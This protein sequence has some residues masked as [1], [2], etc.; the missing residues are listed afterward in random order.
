LCCHETT[1]FE[2]RRSSQA[3]RDQLQAKQVARFPFP[4]H[5]RIPNLAGAE[6]AAK[7]L[8]DLSPWKNAKRGLDRETNKALLLQHIAHFRQEG[9]RLQDLLQVLPQLTRDQVQKLL[10]ELK[11][12]GLVSVTGKTKSSRWFPGTGPVT[13]A[14]KS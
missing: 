8:F 13:I 9:S 5:D 1:F 3:V 11:S 12:A 6:Q 14:P 10:R 2:Q 7:R 4:P